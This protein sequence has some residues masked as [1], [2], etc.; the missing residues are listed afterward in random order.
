MQMNNFIHLFYNQKYNRIE[1]ELPRFNLNFF[2]DKGIL[3][4]IE[5]NGYSVKKNQ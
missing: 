1:I 2:L 4:S 5:F 3:K